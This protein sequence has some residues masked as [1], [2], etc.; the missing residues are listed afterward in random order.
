MNKGISWDNP[1]IEEVRKFAYKHDLT[2][3]M[4]NDTWDGGM[5][6]LVIGV[7]LFEVREIS[8]SEMYCI[9]KAQASFEEKTKNGLLEKL[10]KVLGHSEECE[11]DLHMMVEER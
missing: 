1:V 3:I 10:T 8:D 5:V 9:Q 4:S 6:Q 2:P 11:P 7:A